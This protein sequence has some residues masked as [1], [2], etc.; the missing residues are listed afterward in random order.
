MPASGRSAP[1]AKVK[2]QTRVEAVHRSR[3]NY[4]KK[5]KKR[6]LKDQLD[7]ADDLKGIYRLFSARF[8]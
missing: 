2:D 3:E 8:E 6:L 4:M 7:G 1:E 5:L